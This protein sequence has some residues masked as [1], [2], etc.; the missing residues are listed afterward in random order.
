MQIDAK[1][2]LT[3]LQHIQTMLESRIQPEF[4]T[5][6]EASEYLRCSPSS[7]RRMLNKGDLPFYRAGNSEKCTILI[8][9]KN[10]K[11]IINGIAR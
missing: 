8:K 9:Y 3:H 2:I 4:M 7:I 1:Q 5:I 11:S 6:K 10:I